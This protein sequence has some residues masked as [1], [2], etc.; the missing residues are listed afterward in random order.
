MLKHNKEQNHPKVN[1]IINAISERIFDKQE[2][3]KFCL[4][5]IL[6][7]G[8][9]LLEDYPGL[10]KTTLALSL[11][12]VLGLDY[13]R[14]QFTSDMMPS[15]ILGVT[16]Y[17]RENHAFEFHKGPVFTQFLLADELNR[18][19]A[20]TQ[21]ALLEAMAEKQISMDGQTH[22]LD[23]HF[24]VMAT[25]NP[26]DDSGTFPLPDSQLDRFILSMSL[27]YPSA[28]SER[29][30][31]SGEQSE[32]YSRPLKPIIDPNILTQWKHA[33]RMV[34]ASD[35]TLDY[36]Q[37]LIR[38]TREHGRIR[39]GLSPRAGLA[40]FK[41]AQALAFIDQ[42]DFIIPDDVALAFSPVCR[43]RIKVRDQKTQAKDV[44]QAIL[45]DAP[46]H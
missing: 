32:L 19:T 11:S 41:V 12:Q 39:M 46:T 29:R 6:A 45:D 31:Y 27:G 14:V 1:D 4:A 8:H 2:K 30:L 22:R 16:I 5:A 25:Q 36:L 20:K 18:G 3:I 28:D 44:I 43:H 21:S 23:A 38:K 10:G 34:K 7:E 9:V 37:T 35:E 33:V 24:F 15:D 17:H 40:L 26:L 42:R 13:N